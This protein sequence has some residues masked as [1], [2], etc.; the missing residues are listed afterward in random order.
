MARGWLALAV[1]SLIVAGLLSL[2]VVVGRLPVLSAWIA[3]PLF[4]KRCLVVHVDLALVV[5]FYAFI[6]GLLAAAVRQPGGLI[7]WAG[8]GLAGVGVLAMLA[9][10]LVR[11]AQPVLANYVP[12]ID[13]PVFLTGLGLLF[14][15]LVGGMLSLLLRPTCAGIVPGATMVGL[16]AAA[17]AV[18]LAG[19]T[20]VSAM[21]GLPRGLDPWTHYEFS[22]WGPG[23]VLQVA[24]TCA[25]LAVWMWLLERATGRAP[26]TPR[27]MRVVMS[28][29]LAP[30]F[31]MPVLTIRGTLNNLYHD[32]A[33]QLM[34]W[35][36]F[37]IVLVAIGVGVRHLVARRDAREP[38]RTAL[39]T[40]LAASAG[41][42]VLGIVLGACI[43]G[44]NTLVPA[45]YHASLGAVTATL[46]AAAHLV[47]GRPA[48][49][50]GWRAPRWQLA[51]YGVGQVI[52]ALG[53]ALGG[54]H[55]L[56]RKEYAAEQHVRSLGEYAGLLIMGLG[57]LVAVVGGVWFLVLMVRGMA[58][59]LRRPA[60][61]SPSPNNPSA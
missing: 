39:L 44:S 46:M 18:V 22:A 5:W 55:G 30:H 20:W 3:D 21:A 7:G 53:F 32:G 49:R 58:R 15:G 51:V 2:A 31:I 11:G 23:H 52:F 26:L 17:V 40:A 60:L 28:V 47:V 29:L 13:H 45:H 36:I 25:M 37:P 35:G 14:A 57:G 4:F 24:N 54:A 12:V 38:A 61:Y 8:P 59:W 43:R 27:A 1:G 50:S 6:A 16:R 56:G 19:A 42:A 41:L 9:G 34:R 10:G 33:T 48:G